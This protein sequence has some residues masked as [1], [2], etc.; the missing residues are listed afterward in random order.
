MRRDVLLLVGFA[1]HLIMPVN[2]C[3]AQDPGESIPATVQDGA[4]TDLAWLD[5]TWSGIGYQPA[6]T[7]QAFSI[8][9]V[10]NTQKGTYQARYTS[11]PCTG[12]WSIL[13]SDGCQVKF[14]E[15][16]ESGS[17][18]SGTVI[19]TQLILIGHPS[20]YITWTL[21]TADGALRAW[22]TLKRN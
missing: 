15:T 18:D 1:V 12:S 9:A 10:L 8:K 4:N 7:V 11:F 22:A 21:Y 17:C 14:R 5:G 2:P 16:I 20:R 19:V 3:L 13:S 6:G